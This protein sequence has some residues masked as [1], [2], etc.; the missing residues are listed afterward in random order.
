MTRIIT[1]RRHSALNISYREYQ[2]EDF[3]NLNEKQARSISAL[4]SRLARLRE[5]DNFRLSCWEMWADK[6]LAENER[7][8]IPE[9]TDE[10]KSVKTEE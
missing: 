4:V 10:Y 8:V 6:S 2:P 1:E 9:I 3:L 5:E 7:P